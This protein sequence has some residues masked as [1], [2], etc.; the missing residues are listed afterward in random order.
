M[1][2]PQVGNPEQSRI[3]QGPALFVA[4]Q[5]QAVENCLRRGFGEEDQLCSLTICLDGTATAGAAAAITFAT[6]A[7]VHAFLDAHLSSVRYFSSAL[8][9]I[10]QTQ[11]LSQLMRNQEFA[12]GLYADGIPGLGDA[13]TLAVANT[14]NYRVRLEIKWA[15]PEYRH[16]GYAH[17]PF[18]GF[19]ED[20]GLALTMGGGTFNAGGV[21]W[22]LAGT[23]TVTTRM[24]TETGRPVAKVSPLVYGFRTVNQRQG[25][26]YPAGHYYSFAQL[27]DNAS[28]LAANVGD[29][30]HR[31]FV[32]GELIQ[33]FENEDPAT[34]FAAVSNGWADRG[35]K[36]AAHFN[37]LDA[38]DASPLNQNGSVIFAADVAGNASERLEVSKN[39]V[40]DSGNNYTVASDFGYVFARPM[41]M[42]GEGVGPCAS[43]G[44]RAVIPVKNPLGA[45]NSD[46]KP[47][48]AMIAPEAVIKSR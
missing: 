44:T 19:M 34:R 32:D 37:G 33:P 3:L 5:L 41:S 6:E 1:Q 47:K 16:I 30:G 43:G 31:I 38:E 17:A 23:S 21:A 26:Q 27:T 20:G 10:I 29:S 36:I 18:C 40:V 35:A 8:G 15:M 13:K 48:G 12:F 7:E 42:I 14:W 4:N 39:L 9:D 25:N 28:T 2:L 11:S 45:T 46:G 22:T 24:R